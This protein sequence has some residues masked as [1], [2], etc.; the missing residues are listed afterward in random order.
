MPTY[1]YKCQ[2]CKEIFDE[3]HLMSET[4]EK[5]IKCGS[6]NIN[7]LISKQSIG[8]IKSNSSKNKVGS[9]VNQYIKDATEDLKDQKDRL[10]NEKYEIK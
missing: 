2:D 4:L 8:A 3:F 1:T 6:T 7:K 9:V 10:K 5:C